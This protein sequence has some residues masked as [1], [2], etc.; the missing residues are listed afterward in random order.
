M[1]YFLSSSLCFSGIAADVWRELTGFVGFV[2]AKTRRHRLQLRL[3]PSDL[4]LRRVGGVF[5]GRESSAVA[6]FPR[7]EMCFSFSRRR[8]C[9]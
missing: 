4:N 6:A 7:V 9:V 1:S 8:W 2:A 5:S 3:R